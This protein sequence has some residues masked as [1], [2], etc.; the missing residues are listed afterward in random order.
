M[1]RYRVWMISRPGPYEQYDGHVDVSAE[2]EDDLFRLAVQKLRRT[3]FPDRGEGHWQM[4][5]AEELELT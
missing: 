4:V 3:S 1:A 5:C 2:S